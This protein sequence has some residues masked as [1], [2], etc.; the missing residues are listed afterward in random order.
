[1]ADT[2]TDP[3]EDAPSK[4]RDEEV[5]SG[6]VIV[7]AIVRAARGLTI[8]PPG[9]SFHKR[10]LGELH[11]G[12][13]RHLADYGALRLELEPYEI[14]MGEAALYENSN[15]KDS[16]AFR[17]HSDG[18]KALDFREG[19]SA[20]EVKTFLRIINT[21]S[22]DQLDDDILTLLWSSDLPHISYTPEDDLDPADLP[23]LGIRSDPERQQSGIKEACRAQLPAPESAPILREEAVGIYTLTEGERAFLEKAIRY[24]QARNPLEDI[25]EVMPAI[26]DSVEDGGLRMEFLDLVGGIASRLIADGK[27]GDALLLVRLLR[28][29]SHREDL[30]AEVRSRSSSVLEAIGSAPEMESPEGLLGTAEALSAAEAEELIGLLG[31]GAIHPFSL[32]LGENLGED[33][34]KAVVE[35]LS[36]IG[37]ASSEPFLAYLSPDSHRRSRAILSILRKTGSVAGGGLLSELIEYGDVPLR[38]EVLL[39]LDT[40]AVPGGGELFLKLLRD[41]NGT[42]RVNA[43]RSLARGGY[44]GV[45][46]NLMELTSTQGFRERGPAERKIV[47]E[48]IGLLGGDEVLPFLEKKI[49]TR[50]TFARKREKD[51]VL[52]AVAALGAIRSPAA[53]DVLRRARDVHKGETKE[54]VSRALAKLE[55]GGG[56]SGE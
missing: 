48:T 13:A 24:E 30:P 34:E 44:T 5:S 40:M 35:A 6:G 7:Q 8:Y 21:R 46:Q 16:L 42:I 43:A 18:I 2:V 28:E 23:S 47:F 27:I 52:C 41:E 38:K 4:E 51:D 37:R 22:S 25:L 32:L 54:I 17:L 9:S 29:Q 49:L 26:L 12:L 20:E 10:F 19:V 1:M 33:V 55:A 50:R 3:E 31:K 56:R 39:Y 45:L 15:P 11:A 36:E 53:T 14:R